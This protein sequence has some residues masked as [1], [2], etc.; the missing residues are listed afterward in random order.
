[1]HR[2]FLILTLTF[3]FIL[4]PVLPVSANVPDNCDLPDSTLAD[5]R[6]MLTAEDNAIFFEIWTY[7]EIFCACV[8]IYYND[9]E[10]ADFHDRVMNGAIVL[11]GRTEDPHAVPVLIDAIETHGPQALYALGNF[12]TVESINA[13]VEHISDEDGSNRENAAEGLRNMLPPADKPD[14]WT[15]AL[16]NAIDAVSAWIDQEPDWDIAIYFEDALVNLEFLLENAQA[17]AGTG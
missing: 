8:D 16:T 3:C 17:S 2:G 10:D 1:M 9:P 12:R 5:I 13:L 7:D 4:I 15:E 11:L 6:Q 14:G